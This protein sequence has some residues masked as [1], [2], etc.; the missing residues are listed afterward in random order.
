MEWRQEPA[1]APEESK[2]AGKVGGKRRQ[3]KQRGGQNRGNQAAARKAKQ[4]A[5]PV[6]QEQWNTWWDENW[7]SGDWSAAAAQASGTSGSDVPRAASSSAS[8][9]EVP[10]QSRNRQEPHPSSSPGSR[11]YDHLPVDRVRDCL[12]YTSPSPRDS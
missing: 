10:R 7:T 6:S 1:L 11:P 5:A 9:T 12:L 3:N 8:V 4:E 2:A